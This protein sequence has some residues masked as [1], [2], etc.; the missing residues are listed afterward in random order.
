MSVLY[1][2]PR[3]PPAPVARPQIVQMRDADPV[4]PVTELPSLIMAPMAPPG[5]GNWSSR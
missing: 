4:A 3:Q 5:W 1:P 2:V